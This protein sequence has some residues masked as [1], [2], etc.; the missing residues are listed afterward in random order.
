MICSYTWMDLF[1]LALSREGLEVWTPDL[2]PKRSF[3]PP[4]GED[5]TQKYPFTV[6]A[7]AFLAQLGILIVLRVVT[8]LSEPFPSGGCAKFRSLPG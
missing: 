3:A 2:A 4:P 7:F 6:S 8:D 1:F 5:T